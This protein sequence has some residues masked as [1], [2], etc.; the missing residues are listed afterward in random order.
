MKKNTFLLLGF[1][2]AFACFGQVRQLA[3]VQVNEVETL[4]SDVITI[5][6]GAATLSI[7]MLCTEDGGTT[8]GSIFLQVRNGSGGNWQTVGSTEHSNLWSG[9][10]DSLFTMTDGAIFHVLLAP[11]PFL[12]YRLGVTGT[13]SDTT[14]VSFDYLIS[15]YLKR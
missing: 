13:A 2:I 3:D 4:F 8:D 7:D 10:A 12:N 9:N 15:Y 14:T 5:S 1:L 11:A 6:R